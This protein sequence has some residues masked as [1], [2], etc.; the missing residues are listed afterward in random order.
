MGWGRVRGDGRTPAAS[1]EP[2]ADA[3]PRLRDGQLFA[4]YERVL[5]A[6]DVSNATRVLDVGCGH[7]LFLRLAANRGAAVAGLDADFERLEVALA[8]TP[9]ADLHRGAPE[10]LPFPGESFDLVT[11]FGAFELAARP[12]DALREAARVAHPGGAIVVGAWVDGEPEEALALG[13]ALAPLLPPG[14]P[15]AYSTRRALQALV[16]RAGL[17]PVGTADVVCRWAYEDVPTAVAAEAATAPAALACARSGRRE[18]LAALDRALRPFGRAGA[19][20]LAGVFHY[21]IATR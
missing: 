6:F 5:D 20:R 10:S 7:G 11:G 9:G 12:V 13:R 19:V 2:Y 3:G 16:R 8:R 15:R 21:T 1:W 4:V 18:V 14:G 17:T